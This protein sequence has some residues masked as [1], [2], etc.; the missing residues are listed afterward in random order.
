MNIPEAAAAAIRALNRAGFGAYLVGGCVRDLLMGVEP[1]DI[2]I[3][4]SALPDRTEE[5]FADRRCFE[6][7]K[8]FGT[9]GVMFGDE[10]LEITTYRTESGY[11]DLRRPD[12]VH[13]VGSLEDDL[14]RRDFTVN[15]IA[16]HPDEGIVDPFGGCGDLRA[17]LLRA[18]GDP[19]ERFSEDALRILRLFRFAARL[20]FDID[21]Q[22]LAAAEQLR[23]NLT[24]I[25]AE[26]VTAELLGI[27]SCGGTEALSLM[28]R[29]RI[30][31]AV[32][33]CKT[34]TDFEAV[35]RAGD[36]C[37]KLA[38]LCR[39][40]DTPLHTLF[41][42]LRLTNVQ[43]KRIEL[44]DGQLGAGAPA[45]DAALLRRLRRIDPEALRAVFPLWAQDAARL[46]SGL[47][48]ILRSGR[49][50]R[51]AQLAVDGNDLLALGIPPVKIGGT[52]ERLL[53]LAA[54]DPEKNS[55]TFLLAA[56]R[57]CMNAETGI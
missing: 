23:G 22:T 29:C 37:L 27:L 44:F 53:E 34:P 5:V 19:F 49:P 55:K 15:S 30:W 14:A 17:R 41:S 26:R 40:T 3:A 10:K 45:D 12:R 46:Q 51:T 47:E 38:L 50:Y 1:H 9:V 48:E 11:A 52:L 7:G 57:D 21:P 56:A 31:E 18:T 2:D 25:S 33:F 35:G 36:V 20:R 28:S 6:Q 42:R 24:G 43:T 13:F 4:T 8:R 39:Q 32:G 54:A 16:L